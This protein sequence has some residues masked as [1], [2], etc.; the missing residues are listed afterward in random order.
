MHARRIARTPPSFSRGRDPDRFTSERI[1][2][3]ASVCK[4]GRDFSWMTI[5]FFGRNGYFLEN[6]DEWHTPE[7]NPIQIIQSVGFYFLVTILQTVT[8]GYKTR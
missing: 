5:C 6:E 4:P 3:H 7:L 8:N 1:G 2:A